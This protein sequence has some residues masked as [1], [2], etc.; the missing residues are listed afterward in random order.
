MTRIISGRLRGKIVRAPGNLP[1]RPTTD[2]AKESLF[3][4]LNNNFVFENI[5]ALDLFAGTGNLSYELASRGCDDIVAVDLSN[6]CQQFIEKTAK[7]LGFEGLKTRR[8]NALDFVKRE[9]REYDL[10]IADPPY[11]YLEYTELID[12]IFFHKILSKD[13]MLVIEHD[14]RGDLSDSEYFFETRKYG[15]VRFTFFQIP[16]ETE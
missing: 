4:I 2:F 16:E 8:A 6:R 12:A 1:V 3:N 14:S 11:D 15:K 7:E 9:Y 10:I 5:K 13:G